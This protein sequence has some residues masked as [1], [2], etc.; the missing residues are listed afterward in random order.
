MAITLQHRSPTTIAYNLDHAGYCTALGRCECSRFEVRLPAKAPD[1][2]VGLKTVE[3]TAP[4]VLTLLGREM[5]HGLPDAVLEA[6]EI[7]S[8]IA[9]K[10]IRVVDT[11]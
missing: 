3:K 5:R 7:K 1:G 11:H 8:A 4:P 10:L 9:K 6:A 2:V